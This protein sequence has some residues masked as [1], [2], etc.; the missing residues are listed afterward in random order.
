MTSRNAIRL[1]ALALG[2]GFT[3]AIVCFVL[4]PLPYK[5]WAVLLVILLAAWGIQFAA[6]RLRDWWNTQ[7]S[8]GSHSES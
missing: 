4:A 8:N 5:D 2:G 3:G 6:V 7:G 1:Q